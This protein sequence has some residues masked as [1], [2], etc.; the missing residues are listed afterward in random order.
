MTAIDRSKPL[1]IVRYPRITPVVVADSETPVLDPGTGNLLIGWS[2]HFVS[3]HGNL[4]AT[5][6]TDMA[7]KP[8][9]QSPRFARS[10]RR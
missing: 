10:T 8:C 2:W 6:H 5:L 3:Q 9:E 4:I 7:R 1:R